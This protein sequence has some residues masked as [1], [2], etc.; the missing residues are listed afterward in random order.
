M[1]YGDGIHDDYSAFQSAL[2]SGA[3]TIII[4]AG[5][6]A[7]SQTLKVNSNTHISAARNAKIKMKSLVRKKRNEFLSSA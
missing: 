3:T 4:P 7:I 6:Y 2:D 5:I 1:L